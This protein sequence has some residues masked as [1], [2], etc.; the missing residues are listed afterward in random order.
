MST[1]ELN[2][3][4]LA[5]HSTSLD[6]NGNDNDDETQTEDVPVAPTTT[7]VTRPTPPT[8]FVLSPSRMSEEELLAFAMK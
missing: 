4:P 6:D 7:I 1:E 2:Q 3:D 5:D 8:N